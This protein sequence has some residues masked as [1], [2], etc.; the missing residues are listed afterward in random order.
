MTEFQDLIN[1][2][3]HKD[4]YIIRTE[5]S[6]QADKY[7][8]VY[9]SSNGVYKNNTVEDFT[10]SILKI[11]NYE[12]YMTRIP[13]A[14]KHIFIRDITKRFYKF[15]I[16]DKDLNST[17]KIAEMLKRETEGYKV[18]TIGSSAGASVAIILGKMLN[19]DF[20]IAFS[21]ILKNYNSVLSEEILEENKTTK[22]F[23]NDVD[24]ADS[25]IP[26]FYIYP[27]GSEWDIFNSELL[28]DFQNVRF[29]PIKSDI[30]GVPLN[31]RILKKLLSCDKE[32]LKKL[33]NYKTKDSVNEFALARKIGG[34]GFYLLRVWDYVRKYPLFLFRK[35]FYTMVL[36]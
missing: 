8:V 16:N 6:K 7:A 36:R 25:D 11:D 14:E 20:T 22:A 32:T 12:W 34:Y 13:Y 28:K 9:C 15:G 3:F 30:H 29:L 35:D 24:Y 31:K 33:I 23:F 19:A 26:I 2:Q 17:E 1:E 27:N 21:P 4:N 10:K 5:N 18:I